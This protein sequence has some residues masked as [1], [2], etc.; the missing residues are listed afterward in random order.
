MMIKFL[1]ALVILMLITGPTS[2]SSKS[3]KDSIS[4]KEISTMTAIIDKSIVSYYVNHSGQLPTALDANTLTVMGLSGLDV[5]K[6]S[7]AKVDANTFTLRA[8]LS[9]GSM[10]SVNSGTELPEIT[11]EII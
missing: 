7:Y 6:F 11:P 8:V 5:S 9:N 10:T 2:I 4:D 3:M 1:L